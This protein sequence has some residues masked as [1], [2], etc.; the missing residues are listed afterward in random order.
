MKRILTALLL[1]AGFVFQSK[2]QLLATGQCEE[3]PCGARIICGTG[4]I[5]NPYSYQNATGNPVG[6]CAS[7]SG[8][9]SY[10]QNWM[11]Y[12]FKCTQTG[13][14]NFSITANDAASD[15]DW[16]LWDISTSG[17][18]SLGTGNLVEC[19]AA[20]AGATGISGTPGVLFENSITVTAGNVYILGISR[21]SGGTVTT[22]FSINFTGTTASLSDN[23]KPY[24]ASLLPFNICDAVDTLKVK[25]SEPVRCSQIGAG[26]FQ[27]TGS[28]AFT[29]AAMNCPGCVNAAPNLGL[30]YSN[31]TDTVLFAFPTALAPGT[32]TLSL[33]SATAFTDI[34]NNFDSITPTIVFT[35]PQK[36]K[37]SVRTGF[38]CSLAKYVDTVF[39]VYGTSPYQYKA[40][41]PGQSGLFGAATPSYNVFTN[42]TGGS[43]YTFTAKDLNGC[44]ADT[45][46][47]HPVYLPM[48]VLTYKKNPPC[49]NQFSLDTFKVTT[50]SGGTAPYGYTLTST[51]VGNAALAN[52]YAAGS[53]SGLL[54]G[55]YTIT[56]SDAYGCTATATANIANP[57]ALSF[58]NPTST[59]PQCFGG[60]NGTITINPGG[61]TPTYTFS[62]NPFPGSITV[63]VTSPYVF[64][65]VPA[66]TYTITVTDANGCTITNTK[67]VTS[68]AA[69]T[70]KTTN[71]PLP[72]TYINPTCTNPCSGSI[73][74]IA[75]GGTG[76]KKYYKYPLVTAPNTYSDSVT[77]AGGT[78]AN[79]CQGTYTVLAVDVLGCTNTATFTLAL[80][81]IPD[82]VLDSVTNVLCNGGCS[83]KI[84]TTNTGGTSPFTY[85]I[86][87]SPNAPCGAAVLFGTGDY[88]NLPV[89]T[90]K[91]VITS[92]A[93]QCKDSIININ[94]AEPPALTWTGI[95]PTNILCFNAN[96]GAIAATTTGGTGT[97]T[98]TIT[99]LGPQTN[100]TGNFANLTAQCYT[101]TATDANLC[102][103]T[104][105]V[106]LTQPTVLSVA[107]S[108]TTIPT[109]NGLCNG[110][111]SA[112]AAGG[113]STTY[114]YSITAPGVINASTGAISG[115]CAGPYTIT[116]TDANLCTATS[117]INV[118]QPAVL[119][120]S[121]SLVN[122]VSCNGLCDGAANVSAAGGTAA[123]SYT[124]IA[125]PGTPSLNA[126]T[127]AA[128]NLCA[129][130]YTI[131]ATDAN[132]CTATTTILITQPAVL[133]VNGNVTANASCFGLCNGTATAA[134]AG[135][136][137]AYTYSIT[138]PGV[139][140]A[141]TGAI[142]GLCAGAY[143][144][145]VT[146]ANL[147]T[148]TTTI[149]VTQPTLLSVN[150][151]VTANVSC[152]G[153]CDGTGSSAA[154]GGSGPYTYA[155]TAP[156][157]INVNTGAISGLCVGSYT[158]TATDAGLCTATTVINVTQPVVLSV[159]ANVLTNATCNGLC[160]G[161]GQATAAGGTTAYTYSITAPG[162]IN[163]ST[164]AISGL[165]AGNYTI[166]VTDAN[167]C[168]ATSTINV[169]QPLVLTAN[170]VAGTL[171]TCTP[172]CDG[173]A[174][175][176]GAGGTTAYTY[177][178]APG[179]T[180]D[181]NTGAASNLCAGTNYTI[182]ITD[183]NSC[184]ATTN[185]TLSNPSGPT[186]SIIP[187]SI[188][189]PTC[190][191]LCDGEAEATA[192]GGTPPYSY[193]ITAP[194]TI[195]PLLGEIEDLCDGTYTVTVTD[196][197]SCV[198]TVSFTV[199]QPTLLTV[200][201]NVTANVS[202]FG[203]CN[204]TGTASAAGGTTAY[205]YSI[206]AP[207]V[208]NAGTGAM[209]GL[210]AGNYTITVTDAN[211][212]TATTTINVTEPTLLTVTANVIANASCNGN[213]DGTGQATANNGSGPYTYAITAPGVINVNTG[214]ISGLC[215]G[216]Y[217]I[218]ATDAGLCTA[219]TVINVTQPVVLSVNANVLTNASCNGVCDGT[220]QATAAGGT[221]A[222]TYSIT[223]PGVIN[224]STGA[225][226]GLCSGSYTIT[227]TDANLCTATTTINVTQPLVLT[228]NVVAGT[229]PTC[230]P[231]CD[232]TAQASGA[233]GTLAYTY[234]IAPGGTIDPNTGAASNLC[235]GTTYTITI[236]DANNCNATT[237]INL[238]NPSGPTASVSAIVNPSCFGQCDGTAQAGAIGGTA[239]YTYVIT[240]PGVIDVNTGAITTLCDGTYTITV[241]D[242]NSCVGTISF[243]VTEP[244]QINVSANVLTNASCF[245]NCDGTGSA[246]ANGG[247]I[248]YT[249]S[250][251]APGVINAG[252]GAMSS[253]C[254]GNYTI[255]VTDANLCTATTTINVTEPTLLTVTANVIAN[256]SCNGNCDGTGQAT[257][258]NGTGPYTYAITAPGIID[259]NT[260]AISGLCAGSYTITATDANNC[261]ATTTI[262]VT[263]PVVLSVSANV[264]TNATCNGVCDGTAQATAA[265]GT[266]A[267][268]YSITAPGV[269][270]ASTGAITALCA[271]TYTVTVTDAN[272]CTA[273]TSFTITEP[274]V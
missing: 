111:G 86:T 63:P 165:C 41:G 154:S 142:T 1:I 143:T 52:N 118:T 263:E 75:T 160:N 193:S 153:L 220:A 242:A 170:V 93:N 243:T 150:A 235:A 5:N 171:P 141:S 59:N 157:V 258:N 212:C 98:Y 87:P 6:T 186:A 76:S 194:G 72:V 81:P 244:G 18:S 173:T 223:A 262:N 27:F 29:I 31:Y 261:T 50:V 204:G 162:V 257:A 253:L 73:I 134:A 97:I 256:A 232:G 224:A 15:L 101:I 84:Y 99:P 201:A 206:T 227:V 35:V 163:A 105:Q 46:I 179:G 222:Y 268:T 264:L 7:S 108:V 164:G 54:A 37:D 166:T 238:S 197:N 113:N 121:A 55:S 116:V 69:I 189:N 110:T 21:A 221:T 167:L 42:I 252:T 216:S 66:N 67:T 250:I 94:I 14:L 79:L 147:C 254:A 122:N 85:A 9:F 34:C 126:S 236:T 225:I 195:D 2:A 107:A 183:A 148:A 199:T 155:I 135:G 209:S 64:T 230:T 175:A 92:T 17:C 274:I 226:T 191:G 83:G 56:V 51:P 58:P 16:A 168:T 104:T 78:F 203:L 115:L 234:S 26:D 28:P 49:N 60:T 71:T 106:C 130:T 25:L 47:T 198:G 246:S 120:A 149:N 240:A 96:T 156:G 124:A 241:T 245:G 152:F 228:A 70:I 24:L 137:T 139:I 8:T 205:T 132:L 140:N 267:Y 30:T 178:I 136:T 249:F 248:P 89:G 259:V 233:G 208:I 214:A 217:T 231:G 82:I 48:N 57:S 176:S 39:G 138:A 229:L 181:P 4:T 159:S 11:Y 255:T 32:Y 22:G 202:C 273:T 239:P 100:T 91:V 145:T 271:G 219:T 210:C 40:V 172:G 169:T 90:Y 174:Q 123:Y 185:I 131:T 103:I 184:T 102:S 265:G 161:T 114:T 187:G 80:P 247:S 146:D 188:Q 215:A 20:G 200:N 12:R 151:N 74:P 68:P 65:G 129:G 182:T 128:T 180:I 88:Q 95:S 119:T 33:T 218:T 19:N 213:C 269:I 266:T 38:N 62:I 260:G 53:W 10:A 177:S 196:A 112:V 192:V 36:L 23:V 127:G 44:Q 3:S 190:F 207:G 237:T 109:C 61:G 158:I 211:L 144:I 77:V 13:I 272:L 43:T 125:G 251:T 45:I 117:T 133:S 270:N